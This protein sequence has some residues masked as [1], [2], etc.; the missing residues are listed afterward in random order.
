MV[1]VPVVGDYCQL[2][3]GRGGFIER[4]KHTRLDTG[5]GAMNIQIVVVRLHSGERVRARVGAHIPVAYLGPVK[6]PRP[7]LKLVP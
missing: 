1:G 7:K 2:D 5:Y 6:P 4:V 3:D